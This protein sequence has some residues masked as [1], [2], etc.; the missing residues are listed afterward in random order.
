[1]FHYILTTVNNK[2]LFWFVLQLSQ[3]RITAR[4]IDISLKKEKDKWWTRL[5]STNLKL[6]WL[7]VFQN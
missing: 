2:H 1:M 6:T 7:K 5:T 4:Q 3:Y